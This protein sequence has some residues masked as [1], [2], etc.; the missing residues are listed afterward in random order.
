MFLQITVAK[1]CLAHA[2]D[3]GGLLLLY[4]ALGDLHG[5]EELSVT[6]KEQGKTNVA[7][8]CLFLQQKLEDCVQLLVER[9]LD[10]CLFR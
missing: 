3:L 9:Y 10:F 5:L 2:S 6:A 1:E 4:S 8:L 7:F